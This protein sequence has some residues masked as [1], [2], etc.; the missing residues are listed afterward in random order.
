M[1][2]R[3]ATKFRSLLLSCVALGRDTQGTYKEQNL[4]FVR[5]ARRWKIESD[6]KKNRSI[7]P[8][9]KRKAKKLPDV[10][11]GQHQVLEVQQALISLIQEIISCFGFL[12]RIKSFSDFRKRFFYLHDGSFIFSWE[13]IWESLH[14]IFISILSY[15]LYD[16]ITLYTDIFYLKIS[17]GVKRENAIWDFYWRKMN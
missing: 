15:S 13:K 3:T 2:P 16:I 11:Q 5:H 17:L 1:N 14:P 8:K 7:K 10:W 6:V 12:Y 9:I 4:F